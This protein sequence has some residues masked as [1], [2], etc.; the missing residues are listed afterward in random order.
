MREVR[1]LFLIIILGICLFFIPGGVLAEEDKK[2][3]PRL[4]FMAV[5]IN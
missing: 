3:I 4:D 1:N 2:T 5:L